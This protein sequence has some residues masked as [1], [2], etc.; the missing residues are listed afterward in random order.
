MQFTSDGKNILVT[1]I[2]SAYLWNIDTNQLTPQQVKLPNHNGS[3]R[4]T[5]LSKGSKL[6][7]G[8]TTD[9]TKLHV[10]SFPSYESVMPLDI[11]NINLYAFDSNGKWF[12]AVVDNKKVG[13]WN[14]EVKKLANV[15]EMPYDIGKI[16][17]TRMENIC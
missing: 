3:W 7:I 2:Q 6:L 15:V 11:D 1:N 9:D 16:E 10:I 17:L 13:I 4:S 8:R 5:V 12:A 14:L